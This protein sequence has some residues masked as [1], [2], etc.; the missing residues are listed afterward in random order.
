M[1]ATRIRRVGAR[2]RRGHRPRFLAEA[3]WEAAQNLTDTMINIPVP[4]GVREVEHWEADD[5][6]T[7]TRQVH[8]TERTLAGFDAAIYLE[9]IQHRDSTVTWSLYA[10]VEDSEAMTSGQVRQLAAHLVEAADELDR[11]Q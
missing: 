2:I 6:G 10:H 1:A 3:R 5:T 8:G 9:G 7:W 11:L 4:A